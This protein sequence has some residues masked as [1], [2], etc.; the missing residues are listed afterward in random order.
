MWISLFEKQ[1][2]KIIKVK[3]DQRVPGRTS[4]SWLW[5]IILLESSYMTVERIYCELAPLF[6]VLHLAN[7]TK[8]TQKPQYLL[9]YWRYIYDGQGVSRNTDAQAGVILDPNGFYWFNT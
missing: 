9:I 4:L 1:P 7:L 8:C 2:V 6:F 3:L 5:D